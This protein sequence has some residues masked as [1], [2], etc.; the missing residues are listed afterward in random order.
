M[1]TIEQIARAKAR[2]ALAR[3]SGKQLPCEVIQRAKLDYSEAEDKHPPNPNP[4]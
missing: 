4:S 1:A 3:M 2:V